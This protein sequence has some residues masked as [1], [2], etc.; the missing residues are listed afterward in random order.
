MNLGNDDHLLDVVNHIKNNDENFSEILWEA[1]LENIE[2]LGETLGVICKTFVCKDGYESY[3]EYRNYRVYPIVQLE[4]L[5]LPW[6]YLLTEM[7][8]MQRTLMVEAFRDYKEQRYIWVS[9]TGV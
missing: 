6:L 4:R 2:G 9:K 1:R 8:T 5:R 3:K 7:T